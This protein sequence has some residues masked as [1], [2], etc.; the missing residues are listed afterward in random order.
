MSNMFYMHAAAYNF[1]RYYTPEEK[2]HLNKILCESTTTIIYIHLQRSV[3]DYGETTRQTSA[4]NKKK[5]K[6]LHNISTL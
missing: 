4:Y 3:S 5:C 6:I 1:T 2:R